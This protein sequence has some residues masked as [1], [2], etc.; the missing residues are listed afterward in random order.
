MSIATDITTANSTIATA[1][2]T[3]EGQVTILEN[4]RT[5]DS[6]TFAKSSGPQAAGALLNRLLQLKYRCDNLISDNR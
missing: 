6:I 4:D 5:A 2:T 1:L 3:I